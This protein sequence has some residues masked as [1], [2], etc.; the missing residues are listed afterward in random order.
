MLHTF[1]RYLATLARTSRVRFMF[2]WP[3]AGRALGLGALA[4][5]MAVWIGGQSP[6]TAGQRLERSVKVGDMN[7]DYIVYL[8]DNLAARTSWPVIMAFHPHLAGADY[9]ENTA[10]FQTSAGGSNFIVVYPQ[11]IRR[12]WNAGDCCGAAKKR[13]IDDLGFYLAMI[14][15][16]QTL[17]PINPKIYITGF[18]NGAEMVYH[19]VCNL[20]DTVAAAA[21][22]ATGA[23]MANCQPGQ[24]PLLHIHGAADPLAKVEGGS[25]F[26]SALDTVRAVAGRNGCSA[27][28][29]T[30]EYGLGTNCTSFANCP[31]S[32]EATLCVIPDLGHVWPGAAGKGKRLGP[33]RPD[34][35]ATAAIINFFQQH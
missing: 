8:P 19:I 25:K 21:P 1:T 7:R 6:A 32:A 9:M 20:P 2:T 17:A 26:P 27:S 10:H 5:L 22:F 33:A 24:V 15:D 11:G 28:S 23:Q 18:S 35:D 4:A 13:N 3:M 16:L 30:K 31:G 12:S 34:L 14:A 29:A